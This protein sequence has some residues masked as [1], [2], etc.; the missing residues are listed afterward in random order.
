MSYIGLLPS[1]LK[2][3]M[4]FPHLAWL[5]LVV[6]FGHC[7]RCIANNHRCHLTAE[8]WAKHNRKSGPCLFLAS[9][10]RCQ[11]CTGLL[12]IT[13]TFLGENIPSSAGN[14]SRTHVPCK[15]LHIEASLR[16]CMAYVCNPTNCWIWRSA[17]ASLPSKWAQGWRYCLELCQ[18]QNPDALGLIK[19]SIPWG[20]KKY[21]SVYKLITSNIWQYHSIS[22]NHFKILPDRIS[23]E[24]WSFRNG[25]TMDLSYFL[26]PCCVISQRKVFWFL[27]AQWRCFF[28]FCPKISWNHKHQPQMKFSKQYFAFFGSI[29]SFPNGSRMLWTTGVNNQQCRFS[30]EP[31]SDHLLDR[32]QGRRLFYDRSLKLMLA[33]VQI[34]KSLLGTVLWI[35][36]GTS[37][38]QVSFPCEETGKKINSTFRP[39][40]G[41]TMK[42]NTVFH[43]KPVNHDYIPEMSRMMQKHHVGLFQ[44]HQIM[45]NPVKTGKPHSIFQLWY[46]SFW[47]QSTNP[48][49]DPKK[50]HTSLPSPRCRFRLRSMTFW[51]AWLIGGWEAAGASLLQ[52]RFQ[53]GH[54][55]RSRRLGGPHGVTAWVRWRPPNSRSPMS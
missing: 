31:N 14:H 1:S 53:G 15:I 55:M 8:S 5:W 32:L 25:W 12:S 38:Q 27:S 30:V 22:S 50:L 36:M 51:T 39:Q 47:E 34:F 28:K 2:K 52:I 49:L 10:G 45:I 19:I 7:Q 20:A 48:H 46:T 17:S 24:S 41:K 37:T 16:N 35:R 43:D 13:V 23:H 4:G 40:K 29:G 26:G 6:C 3:T 9:Q 44:D 54:P 21:W 18:T 42:R 11:G 33:E